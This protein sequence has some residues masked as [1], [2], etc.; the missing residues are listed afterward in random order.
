MPKGEDQETL[1]AASSALASLAYSQPGSNPSD[2]HMYRVGRICKT[3][4]PSQAYFWEHYMLQ[5]GGAE[6]TV[7]S[8]STWANLYG[9]LTSYF[10]KITKTL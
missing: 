1:G 3:M 5:P 9:L 10:G 8:P 4:T 2:R 6:H 7:W